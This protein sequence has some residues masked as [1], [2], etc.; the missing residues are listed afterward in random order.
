MLD[1][2]VFS[3]FHLQRR[4][5]SAYLDGMRRFRAEFLHAYPS[6]A[7]LLAR[8]LEELPL[9]R[10]PRF[11]ALLLGSENLYPAQ[12]AY[13]ERTFS[14][15]VFAWY[16]HSEKTLLGGGC[17]VSDDYHLFPQYGVLEVVD[18][19]GE[20][21]APGGRGTLVGT[22]FLNRA[23]P[24]LRYATDDRALLLEGSCRC[25]RAY[26]RL[27]EIEGRW[28]GELL[29]ANGGAAFSMTA[30]NTHST[31]FARVARFRLRQEKIGEV[32]VLVV[33]REGFGDLDAARIAEEY[34][35]RAGGQIRFR[36]QVV[37]ELGLTGRGKFKFVE[38]LVP[39]EARPTPSECTASPARAAGREA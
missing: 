14:C 16:G 33:P 15:R 26:P 21:V 27:A 6:S 35:R 39:A 4:S 7:E 18:E 22:G 13:L 34:G 9:D 5:L 38:Q 19:R 3:G 23:M 25:G 20:P 24:F 37:E 12:R 32:T 30:L 17:E 11:R 36:V 8:L 28:E 31:V 2:V 10:R 29:Y 1:E